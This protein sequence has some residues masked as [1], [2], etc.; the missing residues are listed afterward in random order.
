M[1][2]L[3]QAR[4]IAATAWCKPATRDK[5]MD[6]DLA[7]A[8]AQM[9]VDN[10]FG[11]LAQKMHEEMERAFPDRPDLARGAARVAIGVMME[12]QL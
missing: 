3:E 7:E 10:Q 1:L 6:V 2:T 12:A 4:G 9:L 5:V 8:F 11:Q